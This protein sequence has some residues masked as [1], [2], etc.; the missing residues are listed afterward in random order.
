MALE[1]SATLWTHLHDALKCCLCRQFTGIWNRT[2]LSSSSTVW[3]WVCVYERQRERHFWT[4]KHTQTQCEWS[5]LRPDT[6]WWKFSSELQRHCNSFRENRNRPLRSPLSQQTETKKHTERNTVS[7][8]LEL[9]HSATVNR[10]RSKANSVQ[11][12]LVTMPNCQLSVV[13]IVKTTIKN[14][15]QLSTQLYLKSY[16]RNIS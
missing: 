8:L 15:T 12:G 7:V 2:S 1:F 3:V 14:N 13:Y 5:M 4:V 11:T 10:N 16:I 9:F 6:L